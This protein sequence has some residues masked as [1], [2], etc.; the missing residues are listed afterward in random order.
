MPKLCVM[1][2]MQ[3]ARN[4][5]MRIKSNANL[6]ALL[7]AEVCAFFNGPS[8]YNPVTFTKDAITCHA[9]CQPNADQKTM[10]RMI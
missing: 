6:G 10:R 8:Q 2:C 7:D 1:S 4:E 9:H 5:K 3:S